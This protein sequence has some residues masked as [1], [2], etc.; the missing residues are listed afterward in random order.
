MAD[1]LLTEKAK[2][3]VRRRCILLAES[4]VLVRGRLSSGGGTVGDCVAALF[5]GFL[6]LDRRGGLLIK[7]GLLVLA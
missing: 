7:E 2:L 4:V 1:R 3:P 6:E 5:G